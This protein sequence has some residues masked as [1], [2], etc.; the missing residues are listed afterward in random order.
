MDGWNITFLLGRPIF[1]G[2]LLVSER[3][4]T[5]AFVGCNP[6][7]WSAFKNPL[8][9]VIYGCQPK[10][11]G[12]YP[13]NGMLFFAAYHP[14]VIHPKTGWTF[15]SIQVGRAVRT[16]LRRLGLR[17][18]QVSMCWCVDDD[19]SPLS[20]KNISMEKRHQTHQTM[21]IFWTFE[22]FCCCDI[23][24]FSCPF[25][26][27]N[28]L[29]TCLYMLILSFMGQHGNFEW[30]SLGKAADLAYS[31][32][33]YRFLYAD[34]CIDI[35]IHILFTYIYMYTYYILSICIILRFCDF[36]YIWS[37]YGCYRDIEAIY[38]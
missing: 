1:K 25:K 28:H 21:L 4:M 3:G 7:I 22:K 18:N 38:I 23:K 37:L 11:G 26:F 8:H 20:L 5:F 12:F 14:I 31:I 27:F 35:Y 15:S 32:H 19:T 9:E 6:V 29:H 36:N 33:S 2:E 13:Q 17:P 10:I 34:V 30:H 16:S 24:S